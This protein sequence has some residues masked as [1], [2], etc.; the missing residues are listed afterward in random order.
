[1]SKLIR[2]D[3]VAAYLH[4]EVAWVCNGLKAVCESGVN[5]P[6][7]QATISDEYQI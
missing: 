3:S 4:R 6:E 7:S 5:L 2:I 1:M